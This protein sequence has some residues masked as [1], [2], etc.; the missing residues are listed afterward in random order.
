[1]R[2]LSDKER[3]VIAERHHG[4]EAASA[5]LLARV[6]DTTPQHIAAICADRCATCGEAICG[7]TDAAW[8]RAESTAA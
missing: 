8:A 4:W 1:M 3:R 2:P 5:G 7:C 6:F